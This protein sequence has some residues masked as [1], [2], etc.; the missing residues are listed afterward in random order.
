[1][2]IEAITNT[3]GAVTAISALAICALDWWPRKRRKDV[4]DTLEQ[5]SPY[6][7]GDRLKEQMR[8]DLEMTMRM[9]AHGLKCS[10]VNGVVVRDRG[11]A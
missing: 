6:Q 5:L 11:A 7:F 1:M 2:I 8:H 10:V 9:R 3:C 4:I